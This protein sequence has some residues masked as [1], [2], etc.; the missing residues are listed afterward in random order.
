ME[1]SDHWRASVERERLDTDM[2]SCWSR[3][4][5]VLFHRLCL[6]VHPDLQ[7]TKARWIHVDPLSQCCAVDPG[8]SV[9]V[10]DCS[11]GVG[12]P[13]RGAEKCFGLL[14]LYSSKNER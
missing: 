13:S 4:E 8:P 7:A 12:S 2:G 1:D 3:E 5:C 11:R 9:D 10:G 6:N 14:A